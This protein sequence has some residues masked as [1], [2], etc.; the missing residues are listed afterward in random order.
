MDS[1]VEI[2]QLTKVFKNTK[3]VDGV[4]FSIKQGEVVAILGPNGAGKTTTMLMMLGLLNPTAGVA[5]LFNEDAKAI[6]VRERIGVMLQEVSVMD[7]MKVKELIKLFQS[8]YPNPLEMEKLVRLSGLSEQDLNKRTEK[9]SGGQKRRVGFALALAGNPELLFFDEPTVGMDISARKVFWETVRELSEQG[10]TII[11]TTHYLQEADDIASRI[12]LFNEGSIV[13]DGNPADIKKK[14][15]KQSVSFIAKN[16]IN[17]ELFVQLP[18][19]SDVFQKNDRMYI[20]TDDT[21]SILATIFKGNLQVQDIQIEKGRLEEAFEQL[22][23]DR[24][25]V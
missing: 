15:S 6:S 23:V 10:K 1:V 17:K 4:S 2:K 22:T 8:Y 14:L 24:E 12:I 19:V 21:D 9:L 3:A 20:V 5:R 16:D 13:A 18:F 7:A 25:A 11:F